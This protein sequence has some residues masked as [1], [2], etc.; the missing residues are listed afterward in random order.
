MQ[1]ILDVNG[2]SL[3]DTEETDVAVADVA[4]ASLRLA[5]E[6]FKPHDSLL[7]LGQ[8]GATF[9]IELILLIFVPGHDRLQPGDFSGVIAS[10][11]LDVAEGL[12][13]P[14]PRTYCWAAPAPLSL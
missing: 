7:L 5:V 4:S 6:C 10:A 14:M 12:L 3:G 13:E 2:D 1:F 11:R 8:V 9:F